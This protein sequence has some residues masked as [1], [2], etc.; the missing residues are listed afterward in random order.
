[1]STTTD[2]QAYLDER[3]RESLAFIA[4]F[5]RLAPE[6]RSGEVIGGWSAR[7]MAA[8]VAFWNEAAVPVI[9]HLWRG[10]EIPMPWEFGSG[11]FNEPGWPSADVHNAREAAWARGVSDAEVLERLRSAHDA[12]A[13]ELETVNAEEFEVRRG[14]Y[15]ELI[16]HLREHR[17]ELGGA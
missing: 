16:E 8:H 17:A 11:P 2:L 9:R 15:G 7:E 14:Y 12:L 13:A 4:A 1:M 5:E 6:A 10:Q 3:Q